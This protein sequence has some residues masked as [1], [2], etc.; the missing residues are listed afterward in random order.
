VHLQTNLYRKVA[1]NHPI[2]TQWPVTMIILYLPLFRRN[3]FIVLLVL[4]VNRLVNCLRW[5]INMHFRR[6]IRSNSVIN[7]IKWEID[8]RRAVVGAKCT[9]LVYCQLVEHC[10]PLPET[11]RIYMIWK[12]GL[13]SRLNIQNFVVIRNTFT[14]AIKVY[15]LNL[16]VASTRT[17]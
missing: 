17:N 16:C 5:F 3:K 12:S 8:T 2:F 7:F 13:L 15:W 6:S 10:T 1:V 14:H 11:H 4:L 9:Q